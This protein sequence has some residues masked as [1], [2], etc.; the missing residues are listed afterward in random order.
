MEGGGAKPISGGVDGAF[1]EVRV[2][3]TRRFTRPS[4]AQ[5]ARN[6]WLAS[7]QEIDNDP[8]AFSLQVLRSFN[9]TWMRECRHIRG[10]LVLN[11]FSF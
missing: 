8:A 2:A 5:H 11:F 7:R 4:S 3:L 9:T 1:F 6:G 10:I